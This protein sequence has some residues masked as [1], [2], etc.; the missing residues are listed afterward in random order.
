MSYSLSNFKRRFNTSS[1]FVSVLQ[2]DVDH[3]VV[4]AVTSH[5]VF[6]S[7][8]EEDAGAAYGAGRAFPLLQVRV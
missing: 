1:C 4:V 3:A 8:A 2:K 5:A 7:E 6:E